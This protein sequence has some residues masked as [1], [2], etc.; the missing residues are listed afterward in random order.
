LE[1]SFGARSDFVSEDM[2][3]FSERSHQAFGQLR[4]MSL[5]CGAALENCKLIAA[6]ASHEIGVPQNLAPTP[7][8]ALR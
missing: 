6:E 1:P 4:R 7:G 5:V 3:R 2:V 8:N